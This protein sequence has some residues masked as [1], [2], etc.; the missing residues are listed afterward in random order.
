MTRSEVKP[1]RISNEDQAL[2]ERAFQLAKKSRSSKTA[3]AS[4]LKATDGRVFQG[5][6][7]E[8]KGSA[9]CSMCAEYAAIGAM[10]TEGATR[11]ATIVAVSG[12]KRVILPPCGKCRQLISEFG[13]PYVIV[14]LRG[15]VVKARLK[16]IYPMQIG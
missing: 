14:K 8:V 3:V 7:I 2:L 4:V 5:V 10:V 16:D 13:N 1:R 15:R 6:N 11:I 12:K 9:P